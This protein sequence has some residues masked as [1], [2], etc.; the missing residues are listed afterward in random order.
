MAALTIC[1]G[2]WGTA[3]E[4]YGQ[5]FF[6]TFDAMWPAEVALHVWSDRP[7]PIESAAR[8]VRNMRLGLTDGWTSFMERHRGDA[9]KNGRAP[10]ARWKP[11]ERQRGYTFRYDALRFAGQAFAPEASS[12][13][14]DDGEVLAWLDADMVTFSP[15]PPAWIES[16]IGDRDGAFLGRGAKHSEIGFWAVRLDVDTRRLLCDFANLYRSDKLFGLG[17]WH[18]AFAWDHVRKALTFEGIIDLRDLTPGG[19]GHV[20]FQSPLRAHL[21]HLKGEVRKSAGRSAERR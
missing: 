15:P 7:L 12:F 18:S 17:Q 4:R 5:R 14:M 9:E 3:W 10:N 6:E 16:L 2:M 13:T 21:D 19:R 11:S 20:W 1:T 8:S